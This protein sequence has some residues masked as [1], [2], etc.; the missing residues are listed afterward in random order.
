M[1]K[2]PALNC[3]KRLVQGPV[4]YSVCEHAVTRAKSYGDRLPDRQRYTPLVAWRSSTVRNAYN[5]AAMVSAVTVHTHN[6]PWTT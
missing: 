6:L 4:M 1:N 2:W 3:I 5:T